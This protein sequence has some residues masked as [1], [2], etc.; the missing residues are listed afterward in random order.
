MTKR[1][2]TSVYRHYEFDKTTGLLIKRKEVLPA[3]PRELI[4]CTCGLS[5]WLSTG[6]IWKCD[7]KDAPRRQ[8]ERN[9]RTP[10]QVPV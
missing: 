7:H 2:V 4:T 8:S 9:T 10:E 5:K 6:Q 3:Q 1:T